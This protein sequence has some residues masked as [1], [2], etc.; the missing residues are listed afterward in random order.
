MKRLLPLVLVMLMVAGCS[1]ISPPKYHETEYANYI[2]IAALASESTC[3]V[4]ER[5]RFVQLAN[6]ASLYSAHLPNNE[7]VAKSADNLW[8]SLVELEQAKSVTPVF[9]QLKL[10]VV[11]ELATTLADAAGGKPQ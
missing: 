8:E 9:C 3:T 6:R 10:S 1:I 5:H 7:L 4:E 2:E 11:K